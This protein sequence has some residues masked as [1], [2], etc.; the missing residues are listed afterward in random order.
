MFTL[1]L[2]LW[3]RIK[4]R[5]W[6]WDDFIIILAAAASFIGDIIVCMSMNFD[7]LLTDAVD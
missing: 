3:F 7:V 6:G 4:E 5:L 2:R 1:T